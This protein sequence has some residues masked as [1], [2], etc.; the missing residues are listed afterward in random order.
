MG[1]CHTCN[2]P[3]LIK[4]CNES[5]C[6]RYKPNLDK[7]VPYK[8]P[9]NCP[10]NKQ[11][12]TN[13]FHNTDNSNRNK[14]NDHKDPNLQLSVSTNKPDHMAK[15]LEAKQKITKHFKCHIC[16]ANLIL[17]AATAT[18]AQI[19]IANPTQTDT[20]TNYA[21]IAKKSMKLL[22]PHTHPITPF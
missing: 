10:F 6:G 21:T 16:L 7:H 8:Y 15:L 9:R 20:N 11:P 4:D 12:N 2:G 3:L 19:T 13:P 5:S 18:P 1:P 14:F 17:M 22:I